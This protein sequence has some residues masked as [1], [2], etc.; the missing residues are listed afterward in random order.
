MFQRPLRHVVAT[1]LV[2]GYPKHL[3]DAMQLSP[4]EFEREAK[5]ALAAKLFK[6]G[7]LSSGLAARLAGLE[8]VEFLRA[9]GR[10]Q[11]SSVNIGADELHSDFDYA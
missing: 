11:V 6:T 8:R 3:P 2:V 4:A 7:R 10:Y 1:T 9:L 5:L